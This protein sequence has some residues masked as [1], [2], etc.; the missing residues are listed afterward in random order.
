MVGSGAMLLGDWR[1]RSGTKTD[2]HLYAAGEQYPT[3]RRVIKRDGVS[4]TEPVE[5]GQPCRDCLV[6]AIRKA[7]A[8]DRRGSSKGDES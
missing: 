6:V 5:Y 2:A 8:N 4:G 7:G 1:R 3:C